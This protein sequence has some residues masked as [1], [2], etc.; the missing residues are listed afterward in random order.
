MCYVT[1]YV[2]YWY[3]VY[4]MTETSL[5][6]SREVNRQNRKTRNM[7]TNNIF[8]CKIFL[9]FVFHFERILLSIIPNKSSYE[10][11][12]HKNF[13][14]NYFPNNIIISNIF[15]EYVDLGFFS[16]SSKNLSFHDYLSSLQIIKM[17]YVINLS[18]CDESY[19][20]E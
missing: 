3:F 20:I 9:N 18:I 5:K 14:N 1:G 12:S 6:T 17:Q 4:T 11:F 8:I 13:Y 15:V 7:L 10:N 2:L 16:F 19:K